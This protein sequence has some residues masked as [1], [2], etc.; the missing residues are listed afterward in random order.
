MASATMGGADWNKISQSGG[1]KG[2]RTFLSSGFVNWRIGDAL[3]AGLSL[4]I[5]RKKV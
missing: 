3:G 2:S 4:W 5:P 1:S